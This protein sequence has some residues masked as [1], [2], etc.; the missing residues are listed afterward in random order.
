M[1]IKKADLTNGPINKTIFSFAIPLIIG[2]MIQVLFNMADQIVLGQ[3]AGSGAV[4]SVGAC[5]NSIHVIIS[6][7]QGLSVGVTIL[8]S[9]SIGAGE[10]DRTRRIISTAILTAVGLGLIGGVGGIALSTPL[11]RLTNCPENVFRGAKI[12]ITIYLASTPVIILYNFAAAILR[13]TGDSKRPSLYLI[14]AGALNVVMN[15]ILCL[16]M[17]EKV[18]A[19]AIATLASQALGAFLTIRRLCKVEDEYRLDLK[20][21]VFDGAVFGKIMRYG[22]PSAVN[23]AVYPIANML[24]QSN[25]N[26][27]DPVNGTATAG[28]AAASNLNGLLSSI[29]VG[30]SHT[31]GAMVGQNVGAEKPERVRQSI[32][33]GLLWGTSLTFVASML[34]FV[35]RHFLLRLY[36]PDSPEALEYGLTYMWCMTLPYALIPI[37]QIFG[38]VLNAY[39]YSLF[40]SICSLLSTI[41]FRPIYIYTV[42]AANPTF[43]VLL[44][45]FPVSWALLGVFTG[46]MFAYVHTRYLHG[47]LRKL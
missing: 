41:L 26:A 27:F 20:H 31:V 40:A 30:F 34:L 28:Y 16:V 46:S 15:V 7:L 8:V 2:S 44:L 22:V 45:L 39:G 25:V 29:S 35:A 43:H 17:T 42:F 6:T 12:Y 37:Q 10:H 38:Q 23:S 19:V 33:Y 21:L 47:K 14:F 9:R 11:L 13:V 32:R 36:L 24:I 5:S 4:A 3:M 1:Q 18:A